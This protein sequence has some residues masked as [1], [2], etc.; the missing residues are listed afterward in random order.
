MSEATATL[1]SRVDSLSVPALV[2]MRV[3]EARVKFANILNISANAY[4]TLNGE[5]V[6]EDYRIQVNDVINFTVALGEKGC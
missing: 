2:G 3:S 4:P 5:S 6:S 1:K